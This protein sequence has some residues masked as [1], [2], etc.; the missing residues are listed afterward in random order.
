[1]E[2]K[3][4]EAHIFYG[5]ALK[6]CW[7]RPVTEHLEPFKLYARHMYW[8]YFPYCDLRDLNFSKLQ[9]LSLGN[10]TFTHDW[11]LDWILHISTLEVVVLDDCSIVVGCHMYHNVFGQD[12]AAPSLNE[13]RANDGGCAWYYEARWHDYFRRIQQGLPRLRHFACGHGPW[14]FSEG[15]EKSANLRAR[16]RPQ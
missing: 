3:K 8:S 16:L 13:F 1:M 5:K 2:I 10:M 6:V 15:F 7:L 9:S 14:E 4:E 11:Q 12:R